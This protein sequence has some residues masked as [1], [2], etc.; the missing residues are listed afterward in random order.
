[1]RRLSNQEITDDVDVKSLTK[2]NTLTSLR[3]AEYTTV[4]TDIVVVIVS[5]E[6]R[7]FSVYTNLNTYM[8]EKSP[9]C[10][11]NCLTSLASTNQTDYAIIEQNPKNNKMHRD[12]VKMNNKVP[13]DDGCIRLKVIFH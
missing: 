6:I 10:G 12:Q 5:T 13:K 11:E 2:I 1:M 9:N 3:R 8:I 4:K 7:V